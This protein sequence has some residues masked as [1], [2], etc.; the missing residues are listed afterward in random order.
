MLGGEVLA[1][2]TGAHVGIRGSMSAGYPDSR[3]EAAGA[4]HEIRY[5]VE[6]VLSTEDRALP[7]T[8][9]TAST[10]VAGMAWHRR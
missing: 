9:A 4:H 1:H 3:G 2:G 7:N 8:V 10:G 5:S 6:A